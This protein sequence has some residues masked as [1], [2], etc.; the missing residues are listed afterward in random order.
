MGPADRRARRPLP[1]PARRPPRSWQEPDRAR[2]VHDRRARRRGRRRPR[3]GRGRAGARR[4]ALDRGDDRDGAGHRPP[5]PCRSPGAAL[6]VRP[7]RPAVGVGGAGGHACAPAGPPRS[8][9]PSSAGG[10]RPSY[11][12]AHPDE[13]AEL[14]AMVSSVDRDGYAWCCEAIAAMDLRADLPGVAAPTLVVAGA[15]DPAT[16]V[17]HGELIASLDPRRAHR[18][19]RGRPPGELGAGGRGQRAVGGSPARRRRR[20]MSERARPVRS[21]HAG[22]PRGARRRARR[23]GRRRHVRPRR[24][25]PALHHRRRRGARCGPGTTAWTVAPDRA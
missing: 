25:L 1:L 23:P 14:V 19:P 18:D 22:A 4:R 15:L 8:P 2:P 9:R 17:E 16:P 13:F 24:R 5:R 10:C 20:R 3:P 11:R 12:D 7:A 21:G 6:H